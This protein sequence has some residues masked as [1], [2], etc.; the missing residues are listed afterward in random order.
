MIKAAVI[1]IMVL[2]FIAILFLMFVGVARTSINHRKKEK[3]LL[4]N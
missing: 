3:E 1:T 4:N 2:G